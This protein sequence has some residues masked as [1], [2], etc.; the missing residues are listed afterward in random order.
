MARFCMNCGAKL[1][2]DDAFCP[3]C[4]HAVEKESQGTPSASQAPQAVATEPVSPVE[5]PATPQPALPTQGPSATPPS[6]TSVKGGPNWTAIVAIVAISLVAAFGIYLYHDNSAAAPAQKV[7]TVARKSDPQAK[8]NDA[9]DKSKKNQAVYLKT[10]AE[11]LEQGEKDL[12]TLAKHINSGQYGKNDL[13]QTEKNVY[14]AISKRKNAVGQM[15]H[16]AD[17][18]A[19][20]VIDLFEIQ[21][22]RAECMAEGVMGDT[23]QFAAGGRYYDEFHDKFAAFKK[24][25]HL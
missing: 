4:G 15:S 17:E 3:S 25:N 24:A 22:K 8:Q 9:Q 21:Q 5:P 1:E 11:Q 18:N 23:N 14:G 12:A 16:T 19:A 2:A 20:T 13:L 10:A 7:E 6:S